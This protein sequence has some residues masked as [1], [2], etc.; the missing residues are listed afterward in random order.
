[1][2]IN[3]QQLRVLIE[4]VINEAVDPHTAEFVQNAG[5]AIE[6]LVRSEIKKMQDSAEDELLRSRLVTYEEEIM[7]SAFGSVAHQ[8]E[9]IVED[10]K[11]LDFVRTAIFDGV[12]AQIDGDADEE[13]YP[14][15]YEACDECGYDHSYEYEQAAKAHKALDEG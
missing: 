7:D 13:P 8:L 10:S 11:L 14:A 9:K 5:N 6:T 3:A 4:S 12:N 1:M 15:D 2:K